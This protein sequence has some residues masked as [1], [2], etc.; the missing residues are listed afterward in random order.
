MQKK[1]YIVDKIE[2][3]CKK[4]KIS[5]YRLARRSGLALSSVSTLLNR[6][7]VPTIYTLDKICQG[8]GVTLAQFF[9]AENTRPDL[10]KEQEEFLAILD[11]FTDEEKARVAAFMQGM[12]KV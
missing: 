9:T 5:R 4:R 10:T 6:K 2:M 7:S 1:D 8:L 12:R 3:L 11:E